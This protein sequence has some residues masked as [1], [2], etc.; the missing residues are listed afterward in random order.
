LLARRARLFTPTVADKVAARTR[1]NPDAALDAFASAFQREHFELDESAFDQ[2]FEFWAQ[3]ATDFI[4]LLMR[5]TDRCNG[6]EATGFRPGY[7]LQW[8]LI[9]DVFY[10]DERSQILAQVAETFGEEL[11]DRIESVQPP[12]HQVLCRRLARSPYVGMASFSRWAL[13]DVSFNPV[14]YHH[15]HHADSLRVPWTSRGVKRAARLVRGA[16][17]FQAPTLALARWLEIAPAD[18]GPLLVDAVVGERNAKTWTRSAVQP[19][20]RCGF[21]PQVHDWRQA[22]S[23]ELLCNRTLHPDPKASRRLPETYPVEDDNEPDN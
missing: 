17:D 10:D 18:H 7:A 3:T 21:P 12:E 11:A 4:P 8:A 1:S 16:D 22:T 15:A 13:G 19:C 5:G 23:D 9:Q 2:G 14:L 6:I 20:L